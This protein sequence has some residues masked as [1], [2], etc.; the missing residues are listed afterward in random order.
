MVAESERVDGDLEFAAC[1]ID[2]QVPNSAIRCQTAAEKS[3]AKSVT[4]GD[5]VLEHAARRAI[6]EWK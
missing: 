2:L 5:I 1:R 4:G 6:R 3:S